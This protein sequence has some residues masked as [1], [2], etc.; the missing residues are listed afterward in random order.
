MGKVNNV[1]R[2]NDV[3]VARACG[4]IIM[5]KAAQ[6]DSCKFE[7]KLRKFIN[8]EKVSDLNVAIKLKDIKIF[9]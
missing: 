3:P 1:H 7:R 6:K 4:V 9:S 2:K 8:N 5:T